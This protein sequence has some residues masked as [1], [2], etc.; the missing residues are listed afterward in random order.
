MLD[1]TMELF[2]LSERDEILYGDS[3]I[4]LG[5]RS[6]KILEPKDVIF[7]DSKKSML[8]S[9][10]VAPKGKLY[11]KSILESKFKKSKEKKE[12]KSVI[13]NGIVLVEGEDF[14]F[15]GDKILFKIAIS[16]KDKWWIK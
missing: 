9:S 7:K 8:V 6:I 10:K 12:M 2:F 15:K 11:G 3:F 14:E 5:E 13:L 4:E 16:P 1:K